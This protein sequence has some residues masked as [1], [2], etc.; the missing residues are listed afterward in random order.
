MAGGEDADSGSV[1]AETP[2]RHAVSVL[3]AFGKCLLTLLPVYLAGYFGLSLSFVVLGL[4]V[5]LGW[6][7]HRD[8]KQARLSTAMYALE[9]EW[10][11]TT[12]RLFKSRRDLPAWVRLRTDVYRAQNICI[13]CCTLLKDPKI[14]TSWWHIGF[15]GRGFKSQD[16]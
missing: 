1:S 4:M 2:G 14:K 9:N 6:R 8:R 7:Q 11:F 16:W 15:D 5:Y 12:T 10:D 3:L 13:A